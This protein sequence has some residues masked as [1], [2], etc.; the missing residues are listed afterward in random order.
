MAVDHLVPAVGTACTG[1]IRPRAPLARSGNTQ[2][3][4]AGASALDRSVGKRSRCANAEEEDAVVGGVSFEIRPLHFG[5]LWHGVHAEIY[6]GRPIAF[7]RISGANVDEN[8][9]RSTPLRCLRLNPSI[10]H[11]VR[12][13][14][15]RICASQLTSSYLD[16]SVNFNKS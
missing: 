8:V 10:L 13:C 7:H 9:F 3:S 12:R 4:S 14:A 2:R 16:L 1:G 15:C 5:G 6:M 11:P